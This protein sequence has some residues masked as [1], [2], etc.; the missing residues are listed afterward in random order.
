MNT[1]IV[2]AG[3]Y[4]TT[5]SCVEKLAQQLKGPHGI[6][7]LK[8]PT[9]YDLSDFDRVIIGG[10]VYIGTIQKEVTEFCNT[11][12]DVLLNKQVGLFMCGMQ[13]PEEIE[14]ELNTVF[15]E[16]LRKHALVTSWFG[17]AFIIEKMNFLEKTIVKKIAKTKSSVTDIKEDHIQSFAETMN[18]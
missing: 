10:S 17:G 14:K 9:T 3:K 18:R 4:G 8:K 6:V 7:D 2:Y 13:Q 11:H 1:L 16:A 15:P 12:L 5:Q